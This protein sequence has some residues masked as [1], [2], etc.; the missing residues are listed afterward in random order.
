MFFP[1]WIGSAR[2]RF[3]YVIYSRASCAGR[4]CACSSSGVPSCLRSN[5]F[6]RGACDFTKQLTL[7]DR[8]GHGTS[9]SVNTCQFSKP[10]ILCS[11]AGRC[12][13]HWL[14]SATRTGAA[15]GPEPPVILEAGSRGVNSPRRWTR[16][17]AGFQGCAGR[18]WGAAEVRPWSP[19]WA[20]LTL[21]CFRNT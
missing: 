20:R 15:R 5:R 1:C 17:P 12:E 9:C 13:R 11:L 6:P 14:V 3:T 16:A 21:E 19:P 8:Q 18:V 2:A 10:R 7:S 4:H